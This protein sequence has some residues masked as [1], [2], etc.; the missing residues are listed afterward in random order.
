M[1]HARQSTSV[2]RADSRIESEKRPSQP[3]ALDWGPNREQGEDKETTQE[4]VTP[5]GVCYCF[6][7]V[8]ARFWY[9]VGILVLVLAS[10][11]AALTFTLYELPDFADPTKGFEARG[12]AIAS[13]VF[14]LHNLLMQSE[15]SLVSRPSDAGLRQ[16]SANHSLKGDKLL[17]QARIKRWASLENDQGNPF[18][19]SARLW[20]DDLPHL[21]FESVSG[22]NIMTPEAVKSVCRE[23][24]RFVTSH[25]SYQ[26][27]SLGCGNG[28]SP[29]LAWSVG[30]YIA[31][32]SNR[33]SCEDIT[34]EDIE[35]TV[36]L[37][38][39]CASSVFNISGQEMQ[40]KTISNSIPDICGQHD[41]A[42]HSILYYL[43]PTEFSLNLMRNVTPLS[44]PITVVYFPVFGDSAGTVLKTIYKEKILVQPDSNGIT[45]LRAVN[46]FIKSSMFSDYFFADSLFLCF[47]SV[48]VFFLSWAYTSSFL[49]T[50][51][52]SLII[53]FSLAL[54]DFI[55]TVVLLRPFFPIAN[56]MAI[57][58]IIGVG[59]DDTFV[60]MDFWK[61]CRSEF[62]DQDL[63][64]LVHETLRHAFA[65]MLVT[66]FTTAAALYAA[67]VSPVT[68]VRCFALFAG[69]AII[70]NFFLTM[71]LL[72]SA[73][74]M[75]QKV[76]VWWC[77]P[78]RDLNLRYN[79]FVKIIK[80]VKMVYCELIPF[81]VLKLRFLWIILFLLLMSASGVVVF[82]FPRLKV[83]QSP[84]L[85]FY[86]DS[87]FLEQHEIVFKEQFSA[88]RSR[89]SSTLGCI[90]WGVQGVDNGD[91]WNPGDFGTLLLDNKFQLSSWDHQAWFYNFCH[92]IRNQSFYNSNFPSACFMEDYVQL[93]RRDS[94]V[95]PFTG[96]DATPCCNQPV[97]P[98]HPSLFKT[99][100][101]KFAN[102]GLFPSLYFR[103]DNAELAVVKLIFG[104]NYL[105]GLNY[106]TNN[107]LWATADSWV[108]ET[109]QTAPVPLQRGWFVPTAPDILLYDLQQSLASGTLHSMLIALAVSSGI[110]ALTIR[111]ILLTVFAVMTVTCAIFV[112]VAS[113]VLLGWE[114][115]VVQATM[116]I[117]A[118]GLPV[119]YTI[120]Y[121]VAYKLAPLQKREQRTRYSLITT[122]PALTMAGLSTLLVGALFLPATVLSYYQFGVYWMIVTSSSWIHGT[123]FFQSLCATFGPEHSCFDCCRRG[124]QSTRVS[125]P[126]L[127]RTSRH[128]HTEGWIVSED[129]GI[130][131]ESV[132][133]VSPAQ[134]QT[135]KVAINMTYTQQ[136]ST[137]F[138]PTN[139]KRL[140]PLVGIW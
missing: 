70:M 124:S 119:D 34:E 32:L 131:T 101:Y 40:A 15:E 73:I 13:R 96:E 130:Q 97:F 14:S 99:C 79:V 16:A 46:F 31:L 8:L 58:L 112:T 47:A 80:P 44:S 18:C 91:I 94:C 127:A 59:M 135:T 69:T 54:A 10:V 129:K 90:L 139:P 38:A 3:L 56:T 122:T 1:A 133:R 27:G 63:I 120:H 23:E 134:T 5:D 39:L 68:V 104:T 108:E 126:G 45:K 29:P 41:F 140:N 48:A 60:F 26:G 114:L 103:R 17:H 123:F 100:L 65:T 87:N 7:R 43:L 102:Q 55:Y 25:P 20:D 6:A 11:M 24:R 33:S 118:V 30:N 137:N 84:S 75:Q 88:T 117:L 82:Y 116:I 83:P 36:G 61:K 89:P 128:K 109:L 106:W 98:Y 52:A 78:L 66:S 110:L 105:S 95:D 125:H 115:N 22:S 93:M 136:S 85:Q 71:G 21:V 35:Q 113:L 107:E 77:S 37:L 49:V 57:V 4:E 76:R 92:N 121:G 81:F 53:I 28:K 72:P 62:G 9:V 50:L 138:D 111:N 2:S 132:S 51:S 12:T 67:V 86:V 42:V 64:R 19:K 74:V